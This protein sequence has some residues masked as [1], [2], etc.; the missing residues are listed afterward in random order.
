MIIYNVTIKVTWNIH[1]EWFQWMQSE[2]M[3]EVVATRCFTGSQFVRL[4]DTDDEDGPTYAAQYFANS[5]SDYDRYLELFAGE[6]RDKSVDKWGNAF[7][8]FRTLMEVVR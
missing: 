4:I 5:R 3:P 8:A 1:D 2:H 6:L 7:V